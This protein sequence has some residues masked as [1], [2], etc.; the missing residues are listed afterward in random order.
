MEGL[1]ADLPEPARRAAE[2]LDALAEPKD[3]A[4]G[5]LV[6]IQDPTVDKYTFHD[7]VRIDC[8]SRLHLC[9]AA[10]CRLT[11]PLSAQDLAE[12]VVAWDPERPY[13]NARHAD[14]CCVHLEGST[15]RCA[16]Y[17]QRPL[18]C[19]AFDC[20]N[21]PRIWVDFEKRISNP[22]LATGPPDESAQTEPPHPRRT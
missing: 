12:G 1:P 11:F 7:V 22:H 14:G 10:C 19:R 16:I 13:M 18:P 5:D 6:W 9:K 20:R 2:A 8:A 17:E 3:R 4:D 15:R 21:D